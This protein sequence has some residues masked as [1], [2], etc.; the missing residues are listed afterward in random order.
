MKLGVKDVNVINPGCNY[1]I[2]ISDGAK[3]FAKNIYGNS[4]PK[5]ITV[6]RLDGRKNHQNILM[7]IKN[8]L[9]R[10]RGCFFVIFGVIFCIFPYFLNFFDH[11]SANF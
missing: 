8:I 7:S 3:E 9:P 2:P 11:I 6:S 5:L 1:P 4:S 10:F